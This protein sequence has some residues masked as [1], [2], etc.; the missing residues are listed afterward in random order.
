MAN[1]SNNLSATQ[2]WKDSTAR[3]TINE[4]EVPLAPPWQDKFKRD[5]E[6]FGRLSRF[7]MSYQAPILHGTTFRD[8]ENRHEVETNFYRDSAA[9]ANMH[10]TFSFMLRR[11]ASLKN[12]T[13]RVTNCICLGLGSLSGRMGVPEAKPIPDREIKYHMDISM[14]QLVAFEN[15]MNVLKKNFVIN[16]DDVFLQDPTF[17]ELDKGFLTSL[18]FKVVDSPASNNL[19]TEETFFFAP[20]VVNSVAYSSLAANFPA[21]YIGNPLRED[22]KRSINKRDYGTYPWVRDMMSAFLEE[23]HTDTI[24]LYAH[25]TGFDAESEDYSAIEDEAAI[26]AIYY[27]R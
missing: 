27:L 9:C 25:K 4:G 12:P 7:D 6:V 21:V 22:D 19:I 26:A 24:R 18:G 5:T 16:D 23:R 13:I 14:A 3:R 10:Y 8:L 1:S 17:N 20:H 2:L 11:Q 15:M